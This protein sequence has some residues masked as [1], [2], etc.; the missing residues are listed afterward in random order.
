MEW[1]WMANVIL[2]LA[3]SVVVIKYLLPYV[4][5]FAL[6]AV[7]AMAIDPL[8]TL[9]EKK[10]HVKRGWATMLGLMLVVAVVAS[11]GFLVVSQLAAELNTIITRMPDYTTWV[12]AQVQ[13]AALW[14]DHLMGQYAPAGIPAPLMSRI[15][16]Q[17]GDVAKGLQGWANSTLTALARL[18][19]LFMLITV[20][21]LATYF[22]IR[23]KRLVV[24][25]LLGLLPAAW[26]RGA[27][28]VKA[29]LWVTA[30]GY[31][32]A[33]LI[34]IMITIAIATTGL[35]L[36]HARYALIL[37]LL[38]G[39]VDL[40]PVVG[41]AL[42]FVPWAAYAMLTGSPAF[43]VGLLITLAIMFTVRQLLEPRLLAGQLG[44]HP[45]VTLLAIWLGLQVFGTWGLVIGPFLA[46]LLRSLV[47]AN[48]IPVHRS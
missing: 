28:Q 46:V 22:I 4:L 10:L 31:L 8:V 34:L 24:N 45:L 43:G 30:A 5:P 48:I 12:I 26:R 7:L 23:D 3:A 27:I 20:T 17:L 13:N 37:G 35:L 36:L 9:L 16:Q 2:F 25:S 15:Q 11:V 40:L 6:A 32:R 47:R 44:L 18:P 38:A 41:P 21:A 42:I 33:E 29:D 14:F 19:S 39:V 1:R